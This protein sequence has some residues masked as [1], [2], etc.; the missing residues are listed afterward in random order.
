MKEVLDILIIGG[1]PIGLACG[2]EAK[3]AGLSYVIIEKGALVN[4]LYNYPLNMTFFFYLRKAGNRRR[5]LH[6]HQP[7]AYAA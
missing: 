5:S 4:S 3:K 6:V 7:K 2:I 1:G